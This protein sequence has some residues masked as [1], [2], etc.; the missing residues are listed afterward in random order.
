[1]LRMLLAG[2]AFEMVCSVVSVSAQPVQ[3]VG[4]TNSTWRF[5]SNGVDQLQAWKEKDFIDESW[6]TGRALFGNDTGYPYPFVT[7]IPGPNTS[8]IWT[9][10]YRIHFNWSGSTAGVILSLTNFVD[11]G[12]VLYLN[13]V[14]FYR[15]NMP[16]T[17][18]VL[19]DTPAT[20]ALGE[21]IRDVHQVRLDTNSINPL[22]VGQNV[23][24]VEVHQANLA[25]S[26]TVFGLSVYGSQSVAPCTDNVQPTNRIA[27]AGQNT[28]FLVVLP[29]NCGIPAPSI[30]WFRNVGAGEELITGQTGTSLTLTNVQ[31]SDAGE[32]YCRLDNGVGAVVDSRHAVLTV[33]PDTTP[34][35]FLVAW[36][37]PDPANANVV[38][39]IVD[40]PLCT[41]AS[42]C[43]TDASF[44]FVWHIA[45][46]DN[47]SDELGVNTITI[48]G[49]NI[50][51]ITTNLRMPGKVYRISVDPDSVCDQQGQCISG[52]AFI[53]LSPAVTFMQNDVNGYTGVEDTELE[54][55]TE[56][57]G[58]DV[59]HGSAPR[60]LVDG[61]NLG[62][63][64]HGLL[65]FNNIFGNGPTQVP[66]GAHIVSAILRMQH[67]ALNANGNDVNVYRMLV[68]W[69]QATATFNNFTFAPNTMP[70]LQNDGVEAMTT[71]DLVIVSLAQTVPF[72]LDLDVKTSVQAW[73][74]GEPNFGWGMLPTGVDGYR[75]DASATTTGPRL[76]VIYTV[77]QCSTA[78]S[79]T[80]QPQSFMVNEGASHTITAGIRACNA[81]FQWSKNNVDIPG[82]TNPT[83]TINNAVPNDAGDYRLKVTNPNGSQTSSPA[84]ATVVADLTHPRVV[85]VSGGTNLTSVTIVFS[86]VVS[87]ATAQSTANYAISPSLAVSSAVLSGSGTTVTLT[88]TARTVGTVYTITIRDIRDTR[89]GQN[90]L[91]PNPTVMPLVYQTRILAFR[92]VW[93]YD[94]S[95]TDLG[96]AW[97]ASSY[98]DSSWASGPGILGFETTSNTLVFM[99]TIAPPDGTNTV[100]SLTNSAGQTNVTAYFRTTFNVAFTDL[101]KISFTL[102]AYID[103]GAVWYMNG[104]EVGRFN[105]TN[106]PTLFDTLANGP[107]LLEPNPEPQATFITTNITG[108]VSGQNHFAV[109]VHQE[110]LTSSD[111]DW[112]A[113]IL[114]N[115]GV[116]EARARLTITHNGDGTVTINWTG[117]GTLQ[118]SSVVT[119]GWSNSLNQTKPQTRPVTGNAAFFRLQVLQVIP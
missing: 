77:P 118:E 95:G 82:A 4:I 7:P 55:G 52:S 62:G 89:A 119:G 83:Y 91:D 57:G 78:P 114:A 109:E 86:K 115:I 1:M 113:E 17:T 10:Y 98:D 13:G 58:P 116:A 117:N 110:A 15:F 38:N 99:R 23:L 88:T 69:H 105:I 104:T 84:T 79:F 48:N 53:D 45:D 51:F 112:G 87:A 37:D 3:L 106:T 71:P 6:P 73:S 14:E 32:Y 75:F 36:G 41:D 42:T 33:Q 35:A 46:K 111:I 96:T 93:K 27:T 59:V 100:L 103:D 9:I 34:P 19:F 39:L 92:D 22:V 54:Q 90:L 29:A 12:D 80:E 85:S 47:P 16:A 64:S 44:P 8:G 25:S 11:D 65:R 94:Q 31:T 76:T 107:A 60:I 72:T 70:G 40:E 81:T 43:G 101:S 66:L 68:D 56:F 108:I 97:R 30:Q 61:D 50:N 20:A 74:D 102:R 28:T 67:T 18:P 24:A 21:P 26:D 63:V 2:L 49:T 5:Q